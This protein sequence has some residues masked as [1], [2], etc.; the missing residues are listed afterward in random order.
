[1]PTSSGRFFP[2]V[3][4]FHVFIPFHRQ[5]VF[6]F[7][8]ARLAAG[9]KVVLG[10][11]AAAGQGDDVIHG[12]AF[13]CDF[14][15]TVIAFTGTGFLLPPASLA[16]GAGLVSFSPDRVFVRAADGEIIITHRYTSSPS[17][18]CL[19]RPTR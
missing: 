4:I 17:R 2:V 7:S 13:K 11:S 15:I 8:I 19:A 1:M 12:Q 5:S 6:L 14:P 3:E 16:Q 9:D 18:I 10:G